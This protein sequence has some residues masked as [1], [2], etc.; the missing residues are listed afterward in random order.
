MLVGTLLGLLVGV[1]LGLTVAG[2][3]IFAACCGTKGRLLLFST[4]K[5][6]QIFNLRMVLAA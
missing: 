3:G 1:V 2:G 4:N 6:K 5:Q